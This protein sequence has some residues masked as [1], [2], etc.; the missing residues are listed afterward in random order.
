MYDVTLGI[1]VY[2][3]Q[4]SAPLELINSSYN[5]LKVQQVRADSIRV[6]LSS[7]A[8]LTGGIDLDRIFGLK[9][10]TLRDHENSGDRGPLF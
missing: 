4:P 8:T 1:F 2:I 3:K 6:W 5:L 7:A 9:D 10:E